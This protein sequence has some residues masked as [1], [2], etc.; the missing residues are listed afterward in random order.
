MENMKKNRFFFGIYTHGQQKQSPCTVNVPENQK[1]LE[2]CGGT[3]YERRGLDM[4]R[5][6]GILTFWKRMTMKLM[7][8]PVKK[9]KTEVTHQQN[10]LQ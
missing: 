3:E 2:I 5:W 6:R 9:K 1:H 7:E 10:R 4:S 8:A